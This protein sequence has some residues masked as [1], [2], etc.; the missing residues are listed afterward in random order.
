MDKDNNN[1]F[2]NNEKIINQLADKVLEVILQRY[3]DISPLTLLAN[4]EELLISEL[5][6][7]NTI[8]VMLEEKEQ[9]RKAA[10]IL[11]KIKRIE[12]KLHGKT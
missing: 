4:E 3:G 10:I 11:N 5:A 6:R 12:N 9:Y 8:L 2:I 7:L 1:D